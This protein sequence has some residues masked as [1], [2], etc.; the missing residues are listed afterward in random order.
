MSQADRHWHIFLRLVA[1][2]TNHHTLVTST[3]LFQLIV[4][5][6]NQIINPGLQRT[7]DSYSD[8]GR[9][10]ANRGNNT[11]CTIVKAIV[12]VDITDL[13]NSFPDHS[14]HIDPGGSCYFTS[15]EH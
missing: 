7:V 12:S 14:W 3:N 4:S 11:A 15:D 10:L 8:I 2:K 9:L 5:Q 13:L 1:S 6:R